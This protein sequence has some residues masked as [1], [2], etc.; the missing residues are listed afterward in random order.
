[1]K[2]SPAS[3]VKDDEDV[4]IWNRVTKIHLDDLE[5]LTPRNEDLNS[6]TLLNLSDDIAE[7]R[8]EGESLVIDM[9]KMGAFLSEVTIKTQFRSSIASRVSP[10][11]SGKTFF[12]WQ[13]I[14]SPFAP[15]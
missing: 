10:E 4:W 13:P 6:V 8:V 11:L 12:H 2:T 1:M 5:F 9:M 7:A 3:S 15:S 14:H